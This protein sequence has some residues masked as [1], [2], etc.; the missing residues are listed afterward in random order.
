MEATWEQRK[1][2]ADFATDRLSMEPILKQ[3]R[4]PD[5]TLRPFEVLLETRVIGASSP[6]TQVLLVHYK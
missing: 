1:A 3:A 5:G 4:N 2:T 6:K